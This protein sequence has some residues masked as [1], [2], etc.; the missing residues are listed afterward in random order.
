MQILSG[1]TDTLYEHFHSCLLKMFQH[2][3]KLTFH[4]PDP[5]IYI[6]RFANQ[7]Q[8]GNKLNKV[9]ESATRLV[10][11]MKRDWMHTGRRP[12]GLCG[13]G[14]SLNEICCVWK[15]C[16]IYSKAFSMHNYNALLWI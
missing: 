11:R 16:L 14:E 1:G 8:F 7:L 4:P 6:R 3:T 12:A 13:A 5:I 2:G 10:G 9:V 15:R